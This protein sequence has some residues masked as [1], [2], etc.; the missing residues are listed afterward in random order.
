MIPKLYKIMRSFIL[1][2][3]FICWTGFSLMAAP[4]EA[5]SWKDATK[6]AKAKQKDILL[7]VHG[8]DWNRLGEKFRSK[9]WNQLAFQRQLEDDL[10]F[11][12]VDFL[13]SPSEEE[14]KSLDASI[15]GL[16]LKFRSYPVLALYDPNGKPYATW[17]G[18]KFPLMTSQ[19]VSMIS[20]GV[21]Q[22]KKRDAYLE[23]A[24]KLKGVQKAEAL[25]LA[26][27]T[28]AGQRSE[29]IKQLKECDPD[30]QSGYLSL[31]EFNGKSAI[32][33]TNQLVKEKKFDEA[34]AWLDQQWAQPKL[35]IE[36]KQWILAAKGN[37][38]RRWGGEHLKEMNKA[39]MAAY[40]LDRESVIGKASLR[41]AQKFYKEPLP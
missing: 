14:K 2:T 27:E 19:A 8:S 15:K 20:H 10:V 6:M 36:Q 31:L 38:Y 18:S 33:H 1:Q 13:E 4:S 5:K 34:I 9:I 35:N 41:L 12:R 32:G 17:T 22:R 25:Y 3:L 23:E 11:F 29:I 26:I 24:K 40:A 39:F 30:N 16:K 7:F 28:H 37:V 21:G